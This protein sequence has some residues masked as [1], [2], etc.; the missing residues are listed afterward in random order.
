MHEEPLQR[1]LHDLT[2]SRGVFVERAMELGIRVVLMGQDGIEDC[3]LHH[4][5][6]DVGE[7]I[8]LARSNEPERLRAIAQ[9]Q[10]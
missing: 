2:R 4:A 10:G 9:R 3:E 8:V 6:S 7:A 5:R 1:A